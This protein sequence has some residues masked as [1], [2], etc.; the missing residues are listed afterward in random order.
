MSVADT[1]LWPARQVAAVP[2]RLWSQ[3]TEISWD[4]YFV[5]VF[6]RPI[7]NFI[8]LNRLMVFWTLGV[9]SP[10]QQMAGSIYLAV[11]LIV[12]SLAALTYLAVIFIIPFTIGALRLLPFV[13]GLWQRVTGTG[14]GNY[15]SLNSL[16]FWPW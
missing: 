5:F 3:L 10:T 2:G 11:Q 9:G 7:V 16:D 8:K 6:I 13:D 15:D 14:S 1:V 4:G 12:A